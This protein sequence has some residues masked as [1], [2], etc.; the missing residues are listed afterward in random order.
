MVSDTKE[1]WRCRMTDTRYGEKGSF[2][3]CRTR[4]Y[5][6]MMTSRNNIHPSS[7]PRFRPLGNGSAN[8]SETSAMSD[9]QL[10]TPAKQALIALV[11]VVEEATNSVLQERFG[12]KIEKTT[13][14][15]LLSQELI[16][17]GKGPNN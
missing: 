9:L 4:K 15:L 6:V 16:T 8:P 13:R 11:L 10:T 1:C 2:N 17:V 5:T 12:S 14:E 3:E 7:P